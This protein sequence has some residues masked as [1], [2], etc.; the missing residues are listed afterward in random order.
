MHR[1][2]THLQVL[3]GQ[4][5]ELPPRELLDRF[6][7]LAAQIPSSSTR[8]EELAVANL[9]EQAVQRLG[10]VLK[11]EPC[12]A[13]SAHLHPHTFREAL[14]RVRMHHMSHSSRHIA[15]FADIVARR[16]EESDLS[17]AKV[18]AEMRLSA[19]YVT[20][21]VRRHTGHGF[22]WH[23]HTYRIRKAKELLAE[24]TLSVKEI[25]AHVGYART[26]QFDRRF[27]VSTGMT[28]TEYRRLR[29]L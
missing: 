4:L 10:R 25:S 24:S 7:E 6:D 1:F 27:R 29:R 2:V 17:V 23:L 12:L 16:Y 13:G 26:S 28:P 5:T 18:A 20:R 19:C 8:I 11:A 3:A 22:V 21:I 14:R 15:K 9:L